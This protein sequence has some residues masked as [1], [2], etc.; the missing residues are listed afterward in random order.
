MAPV[1]QE[2]SVTWNGETY[3]VKSDYALIQ[4]VEQE[5][6][7]AA[8]FNRVLSK[9]PPLSQLADLLAAVL[10]AAGC[11][12]ETATGENIN[13]ALY[14]ASPE[15]RDHLTTAASAILMELLPVR[16]P[17]GNAEAPAEGASQSQKSTGESTTKSQ[18]DTAESNPPNSGE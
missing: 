1:Y 6:S 16:A 7:L 5:I 13:S 2:I 14:N 9:R 15:E 12:D 17:R 18:S 10:R 11:E 8:L 3:K 4:R